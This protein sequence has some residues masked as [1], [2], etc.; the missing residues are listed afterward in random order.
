MCYYLPAVKKYK[1]PTI[2]EIF[3]VKIGTKYVWEERV[4]HQT[5]LV[6]L[7]EEIYGIKL[8]FRAFSF[9]P[10][11]L[12]F[13]M[14]LSCNRNYVEKAKS[15]WRKVE[16]VFEANKWKTY[17]AFRH[18][19]PDKRIPQRFTTFK[20]VGFGYTQLLL[21][22][23][24]LMD[25]NEPSHGVGRQLEL[26]LFQPLIGFSKNHVSR[27]VSGR[28]GSLIINY[29]TDEELL[30][31]LTK[32]TKRKS[33]RKEPFYVKKCRK[34]N[35]KAVFKGKQCLNCLFEKKF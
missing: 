26:S 7:L 3:K 33:F 5:T 27:M 23:L 4:K 25:L 12:Y 31:I 24:V 15:L 17:S 21:S 35:L 19:N 2:S 16:T 13:G 34:H 9:Y 29:Q 30:S 8:N 1:F 11:R 10:N 28:P 18:V 22:E 6:Y 20:D 32:I 14:P